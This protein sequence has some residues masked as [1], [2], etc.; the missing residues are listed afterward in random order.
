MA[1]KQHQ[2]VV[3]PRKA[4]TVPKAKFEALV[5]ARHVAAR[6][7]REVA[8][9]RVGMLV[10]MAACGAVGYLEKEEKMPDFGG[11]VPTVIG[12]VVLGFIGPMLIKGRAGSAM[13][14][15]GSALGG[16]AAYKL[17][18]GAPLYESRS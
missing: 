14:E 8:G 18:K 6:K 15:A 4:P 11:V 7:T 10:G 1:K 9:Q 17:A 2:V 13:A 16:V 3:A 5:R 12:A